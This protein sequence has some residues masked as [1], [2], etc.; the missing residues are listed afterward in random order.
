MCRW[1]YITCRTCTIVL[2]V[3]DEQC[4][5]MRRVFNCENGQAFRPPVVHKVTCYA[6]IRLRMGWIWRG[7]E[8]ESARRVEST[9]VRSLGERTVESWLDEVVGS[10]S[11]ETTTS[12]GTEESIAFSPG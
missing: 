6:C 2:A 12:S 9:D 5:L 7:V 1:E 11:A 10:P 3:I 4:D 8:G